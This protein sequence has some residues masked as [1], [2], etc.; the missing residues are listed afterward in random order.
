MQKE[1]KNKRGRECK[2]KGKGRGRKEEK[3]I[4]RDVEWEM[5]KEREGGKIDKGVRKRGK[6]EMG[7]LREE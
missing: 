7:R 6:R 3:G 2:R 4:K 5:W 1:L